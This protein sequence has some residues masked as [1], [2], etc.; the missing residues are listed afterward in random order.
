MP[1]SRVF[2][3]NGAKSLLPLRSSLVDQLDPELE[4]SRVE[5]GG[6]GTKVAGSFVDADAAVVDIALELCVIP[7]VEALRA[8]LDTAA[9]RFADEKT[10][11][12]REVPIV[13]AGTAQPV[14][15]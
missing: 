15:A 5:R 10:L 8:E 4:F 13:T 11:E 12:E 3:V 1:R 14:E 9:A 7:G 2:D 6:D